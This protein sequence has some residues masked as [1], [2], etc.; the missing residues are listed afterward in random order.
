MIHAGGAPSLLSGFALWALL[1]YFLAFSLVLF[2]LFPQ[3]RAHAL[4]ALIGCC[5][6]AASGILAYYQAFFASH[7]AQ[8]ALAFI[9]VPIYQLFGSA[10]L[11]LLLGLV[12]LASFIL[13]SNRSA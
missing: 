12:R 6:L 3:N 1:P 13:R 9:F 8:N 2:P 10:V 5:V 11:L 4:G 7:D